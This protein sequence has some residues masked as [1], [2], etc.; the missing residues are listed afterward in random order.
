MKAEIASRA[1]K[2]AYYFN[3]AGNRSG[4]GSFIFY[5]VALDALFGSQG[6]VEVGIES[7]IARAAPNYIDRAKLLYSLRN[8]MVHG[9]SR[10]L[11]EWGDY[12][13]YVDKFNSVPERDIES[14]ELQSL[15]NFPFLPQ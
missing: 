4:L 14:I 3:L 11:P 13:K 12:Q 6:R 10:T 2:G 9:G 1:D 15:R 5:Y 7:G 8:E